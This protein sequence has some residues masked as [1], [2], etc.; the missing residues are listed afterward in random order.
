MLVVA[1]EPHRLDNPR[2][3]VG[4]LRH[5][6]GDAPTGGVLDRVG[7][8]A[9]DVLL[10]PL[11]VRDDVAADPTRQRQQV[12][13]DARLKVLHAADGQR[14]DLRQIY[15]LQLRHKLDAFARFGVVDATVDGHRHK[16]VDVHQVSNVIADGP[17]EGIFEIS[18]LLAFV[19][20][21]IDL[22]CDDLETVHQ[23]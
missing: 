8:Q 20:A 2:V 7:D 18:I 11:L 14:E 1:M 10:Q 13:R 3:S 16:T 17:Q 6:N 5:L 21:G 9:E 15:G 12:N 22:V 19:N 4:G 23:S